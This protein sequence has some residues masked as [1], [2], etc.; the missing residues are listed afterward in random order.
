MIDPY[1]IFP[2]GPYRPG[3]TARPLESDIL[4]EQISALPAVVTSENW[5]NADAY[6]QGIAFFNDRFYWE[7]HEVWEGVWVNCLPNSRERYLLQGLVQMTNAALKTSIG[8]VGAAVKLIELSEGLLEEAF[9]RRKD[10]IMGTTWQNLRKI[11]ES[12][13]VELGREKNKGMSIPELE[14]E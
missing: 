13:K 1:H 6:F 8:M 7:A 11:L 3:K 9:G 5:R 10:I 14:I 4:K 12:L 2:D